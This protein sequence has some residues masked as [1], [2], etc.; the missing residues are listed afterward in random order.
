[1][2]VILMEHHWED[3]L[4][5]VFEEDWRLLKK[6]E[7]PLEVNTPISRDAIQPK[8]LPPRRDEEEMTEEEPSAPSSSWQIPTLAAG[9]EAAV[10]HRLTYR[11]G[12]VKGSVDI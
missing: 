10:D 6:H 9:E 7:E 2:P 5:L 4:F 3:T 12:K 11:T 1:L 8:S